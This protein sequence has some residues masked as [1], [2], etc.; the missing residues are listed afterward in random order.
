M[1]FIFINNCIFR[2]YFNSK[3]HRKKYIL[4]KFICAIVIFFLLIGFLF[5]AEILILM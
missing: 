2:V 5:T 1:Y 4:P 3:V